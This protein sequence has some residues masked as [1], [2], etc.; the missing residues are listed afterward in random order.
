MEHCKNLDLRDIVY[1]C[2]ID[3]VKHEIS[4]KEAYKEL[5]RLWTNKIIPEPS[6]VINSGRGL[7]VYWHLDNCFASTKNNVSFIP[8]YQALLD[9]MAQK[10][11]YLGAP[12][13]KTRKS[14]VKE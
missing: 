12:A 14:P 6:L 3:C 2:D 8:T 9:R 13:N 11:A 5:V 4:F 7:H 10:L 1:F